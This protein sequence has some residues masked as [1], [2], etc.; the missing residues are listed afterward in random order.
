MIRWTL[1]TAALLLA[2]CGGGKDDRESA[3]ASAE[4]PT[5]PVEPA[6]PL[7]APPGPGAGPGDADLDYVAD[8]ALPPPAAPDAGVGTGDQAIPAAIRGRWALK[9][10]DCT[11]RKGTD[12]SALVIDAK[13]LRFF[14][15]AGDLARARDHRANR[16]IADFKF[17]GEGEQWDRLMLLGLADGGKT[18]VRRDYGEGAD[19]Q[20]L[21]YTRCTA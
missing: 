21:R 17:S 6:P 14:E 1:P 11:A 13:T 4:A 20:P 18:L 16:I 19:P 5:A 10:A 3:R 7:P 12:L 2:A 15:S 8:P 9:A